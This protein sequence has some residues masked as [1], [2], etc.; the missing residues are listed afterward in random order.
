MDKGKRG[1]FV[2]HNKKFVF[3]M[4]KKCAS[5]TMGKTILSSLGYTDLSGNN[6][7]LNILG[8]VI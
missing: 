1:N 6:Y 2:I 3:M 8:F 7:K 5:V 4:L